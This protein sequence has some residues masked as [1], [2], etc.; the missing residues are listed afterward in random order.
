[1]ATDLYAGPVNHAVFVVPR[2]S[3]LSR[4]AQALVRSGVGGAFEVLDLEVVALAADG[5]AVRLSAE[6]DPR[7]SEFDTAFT[8]LLDDEDLAALGAELAVGEYAIVVVYEDR[9]LAGVA[10]EVQQNGGRELWSGGVALEDLE[11]A[12][13]NSE[14]ER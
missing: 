1:M 9:G 5:A 2:E 13:A 8:E 6:Q 12:I 4:V 3:D 14:D 7:L 10:R 11:K